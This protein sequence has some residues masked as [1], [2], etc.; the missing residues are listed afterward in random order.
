V[1]SKVLSNKKKKGSPEGG[2]PVLVDEIWIAPIAGVEVTGKWRIL[3][4]S[5]ENYIRVRD[6]ILD[7]AMNKRRFRD[8]VEFASYFDVDP[9]GGVVFERLLAE[10]FLKRLSTRIELCR[11]EPVTLVRVLDLRIDLDNLSSQLALP[12]LGE[13]E[14]DRIE[15]A[16]LEFS[17][18]PRLVDSHDQIFT[19]MSV[20]H[21][22]AQRPLFSLITQD[23]HRQLHPYSYL[24]RDQKVFENLQP[25]FLNFATFLRA[26]KLEKLCRELSRIYRENSRIVAERLIEFKHLHRDPDL[27]RLAALRE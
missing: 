5:A 15:A 22:A 23:L 9:N 24:D 1:V 16:G 14:L 7:P 10:G 2:G 12:R 4:G 3:N 19:I 6:M 21:Q 20:L 25:L 11:F 13:R 17:K 18:G 27:E 8:E 26:G